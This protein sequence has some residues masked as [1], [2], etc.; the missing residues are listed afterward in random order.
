MTIYYTT[1][2]EFDTT[3]KEHIIPEVFDAGLDIHFT[4][5][6][7]DAMKKHIE[8]AERFSDTKAFYVSS[9]EHSL[10]DGFPLNTIIKYECPNGQRSTILIETHKKKIN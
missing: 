5:N 9:V 7:L 2:Q 3:S 8:I 4:T 1:V 10:A 6:E